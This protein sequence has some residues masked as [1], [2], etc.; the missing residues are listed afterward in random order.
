MALTINITHED[1]QRV[2]IVV[3]RQGLDK[4]QLAWLQIYDVI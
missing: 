1:L 4:V 3:V 2:S